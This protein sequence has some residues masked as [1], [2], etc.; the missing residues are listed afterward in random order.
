MK[1]KKKIKWF[2]G[3]IKYSIFFGILALISLVG[4]YIHGKFYDPLFSKLYYVMTIVFVVL[5]LYWV[6]K[7]RKYKNS[8]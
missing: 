4:G 5:T 1:K 6:W 8:N 7:Q 2:R 3:T